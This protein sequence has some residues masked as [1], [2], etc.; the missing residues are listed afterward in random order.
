MPASLAEQ[1]YARWRE[2]LPADSIWTAWATL[3]PQYRAAWEAVAE[4]ARTIERAR[5]SAIVSEELT[6]LA[7][8]Q[9]RDLRAA[10]AL[11]EQRLTAW[12]EA[13][14][15]EGVTDEQ[16]ERALARAQKAVLS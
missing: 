12:G 15:A 4:V 11:S 14:Q 10:V 5:A 9:R 6:R 8:E 3:D 7:D 1:L 13:L 2:L 16:M